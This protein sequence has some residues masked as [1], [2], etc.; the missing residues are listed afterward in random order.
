MNER[1]R[2][3][4]GI[5]NYLEQSKNDGVDFGKANAILLYVECCACSLFESCCGKCKK[6]EIKNNAVD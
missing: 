4:E 1:E 5:K 6:K 3:W 2:H